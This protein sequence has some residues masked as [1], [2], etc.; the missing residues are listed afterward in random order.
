MKAIKKYDEYIERIE[1]HEVVYS[2]ANVDSQTLFE[3]Y[4]DS[5]RIGNSEIDFGNLVWEDKVPGIV[6]AM[7]EHGVERFTVSTNQ[8]NVQR[9]IAAF[10]DQ[11]NG[12]TIDGMK[13]VLSG[14]VVYGVPEKRPAFVMTLIYPERF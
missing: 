5:K 9:L 12:M 4:W 14:R 6:D 11:G 1:N 7:I 13:D 2:P 3:A 8:S 10:M